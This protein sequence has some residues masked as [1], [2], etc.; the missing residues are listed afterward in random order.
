MAS[1]KLVEFTSIVTRKMWFDGHP[2]LFNILW[3]T[4]KYK[5]DK[6]KYKY[7]KI[8]NMIEERYKKMKNIDKIFKINRCLCIYYYLWSQRSFYLSPSKW[9]GDM[10]IFYLS[11]FSFTFYWLHVSLTIFI[12]RA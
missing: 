5:Y 2:I 6:I 3:E 12:L 8:Y 1:Y 10:S 11:N 4:E 7:D 9:P